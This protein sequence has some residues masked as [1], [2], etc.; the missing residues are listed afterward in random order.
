MMP[1][2]W[3][4]MEILPIALTRLLMV[5]S[6][7]ISKGCLFRLILTNNSTVKCKHSATA[8]LVVLDVVLESLG[9][10]RL[11]A[12][13]FVAIGTICFELGMKNWDVFANFLAIG[14]VS[15]RI[16]EHQ[17][18]IVENEWDSNFNHPQS[19]HLGT[20]GAVKCY[21]MLA[22]EKPNTYS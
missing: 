11:V 16:F 8:D 5:S 4:K 20:F 1:V 7:E 13:W 9:S 18:K 22:Y 15:G 12:S 14:L 6:G 21:K 10:K 3:R 17:L 19:E 2:D